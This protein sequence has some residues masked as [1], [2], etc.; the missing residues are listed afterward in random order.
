[1]ELDYKRQFGTVRYE[2][3]SIYVFAPRPRGV[4]LSTLRSV[5][6]I[7]DRTA[8]GLLGGRARRWSRKLG[9]LGRRSAKASDDVPEP[10]PARR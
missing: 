1:M 4:L 8:R 6:G 3:S 2:R 7:A 9:G 10:E 5:S